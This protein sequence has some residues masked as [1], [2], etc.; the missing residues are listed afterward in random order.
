MVSSLMT[1]SMALANRTPFTARPMPCRAVPQQ[2]ARVVS[3]AAQEDA[4]RK[5]AQAP[6]QAVMRAVGALAAVQLAF[7]PAAGADGLK[8]LLPSSATSESAREAVNERTSDLPSFSQVG[9]SLKNAIGGSSDPKDIGRAINANTPDGPDLTKNPKALAQD[10][11]QG[12]KDLAGKVQNAAP[13]LSAVD[14]PISDRTG[15][16][17]PFDKGSGTIPRASDISELAG[18][19]KREAGALGGDVAK[20]TPDAGDIK[21]IGSKVADKAKGAASKV[22]NAVGDSAGLFDFG[23]AQ[24]TAQEAGVKAK[25]AAN[26]VQNKVGNPLQGASSTGNKLANKAGDLGKVGGDLKSKANQVGR[27]V[28]SA[29]GDNAGLPSPQEAADKLKGKVDEV[30]R[31][32]QGVG[33]NNP[34]SGNVPSPQEAG[35]K[36]KGKVNEAGRKAQNVVGDNAGL[37]S[38]QEAADKIKGKV[39]EVG[40][41]VQGVGSNNPLSGNVPSPQEA[42]DKLKGKVNEAG[43]KAQ[44]AVGDN[45]GLP[46][47][48]EA[49]DKVKAALPGGGGGAVGANLQSKAGQIKDKAADF[50]GASKDSNALTGPSELV[51]KMETFK[52]KVEGKASGLGGKVQG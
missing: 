23:K 12:A 33:S 24:G 7:L 27:K 5:P 30:G 43:R 32:V 17:N 45:A 51:D 10:A 11:K 29:V 8:D 41:N 46:S 14:E 38:P 3:A 2:R 20:N 40:R 1:S 18:R 47:P 31:N 34:L 21:S 13:D 37:P 28:Q 16:P 6:N 42:G 22:Q 49:A 36:L 50:P 25:G 4:D 44:N 48:G 19:A 52:A 15:L 9:A 35:D 26:A 39:D